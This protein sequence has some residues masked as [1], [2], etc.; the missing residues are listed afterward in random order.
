MKTKLNENLNHEN[1]FVLLLKQIICRLN[2]N[3]HVESVHEHIYR[4]NGVASS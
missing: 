2:E 1:A 3:I 4:E